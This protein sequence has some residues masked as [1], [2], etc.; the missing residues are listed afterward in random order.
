[1]SH[2]FD[3]GARAQFFDAVFAPVQLDLVKTGQVAHLHPRDHLALRVLGQRPGARVLDYGCGQGRL[4][5][6]LLGRGYDAFG[7]EPSVGMADVARQHFMQDHGDRLIGGSADNLSSWPDAHFDVVLLMGVT[8]YLSDQ[9][10]VETVARCRRLLSPEGT[11]LVTFQ[12]GLFDLFTFNKYTV[13]ALMHMVLGASLT[14][15]ERPAV[16]AAIEALLVNPT[17]PA[18]SSSRARDNVFV[19]LSNP[20]TIDADLAALGFAR[21]NLWFYEWF[22]LPPLATATAPETA[23]RIKSSFEVE[24]AQDWRGHFMANAFL[25]EATPEGRQG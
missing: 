12:N 7:Y 16:Q 2:E 9:E 3:A 22:G 19:R 6:E 17:M 23:A 21:R 25:V 10:L 15:P 18:H 5:N 4:L 14:P 20:L 11:L 13:D 8:Q 24:R 1:M